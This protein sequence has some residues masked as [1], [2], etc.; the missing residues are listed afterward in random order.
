MLGG[1]LDPRS[2]NWV[3]WAMRGGRRV[4]ASWAGSWI[5]AHGQG[6][7]FFIYPNLFRN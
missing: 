6:K 2:A 7:R 3:D 5:S 4:E 1:L